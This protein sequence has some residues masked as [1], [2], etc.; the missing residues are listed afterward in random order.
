MEKKKILILYAPL[1]VGH[2]SAASAIAEVF[3]L[4]RP[5]IE[6]KNI[7]VLDFVPDV[8]KQGL[9]W[10]YNQTTS[11]VPTLYKLIY[12][13]Y[14][15]KSRSKHLNNLSRIILKKSKFIEF[16]EDFNPDFII[17]TNP[18]AM[19]LISLTKEENIINIPSANVCKD[20]GFYSLWHNKDAN[21]YFVANEEIKKSLIKYGAEKNKIQITGIPTGLKFSKLLNIKEI[22]VS[23]LKF[24]SANPVLLIVGGRISYFNLLKIIKGVKKNN[25]KIQ[26]IVVAG[27]DKILQKKIKDSEITIDPAIRVFDFVDNLEEYMTVADLI[28]TKAGGLTVS[29]CLVKNLP[30][31]FNDIIPGQEEDNVNYAV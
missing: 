30:M 18:L 11:K 20:F 26:F 14:N 25:T 31:I 6:V 5:D 21:Y 12:N 15:Y 3:A 28:L 13:Y 2:S 29:E 24:N 9:P 22:I 19:Q 16:I 27:R 4:K 7:N 17:S 10:F 23:K 8:F 1:G